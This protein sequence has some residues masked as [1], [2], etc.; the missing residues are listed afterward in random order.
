MG[1]FS[2]KDRTPVVH[3]EVHR[4]IAV[5]ARLDAV[6]EQLRSYSAL[7]SPKHASLHRLLLSEDDGWTV[8]ELPPAIHPW[9]F[10]NM[11][12]WLL[13]T[14]GAADGTVIRSG[15]T[16]AYAAYSLVRDPEVADC[17]CGID[18]NGEGWT[19]SVPTNRI[20]RPAP[21][22]A[23]ARAVAMTPSASAHTIE[24]LAEDPGRDMNP[25]NAPTVATRKQLETVDDYGYSIL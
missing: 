14:S 10:H 6:V 11:G 15:A 25:T 3:P 16:A 21:V 22:P 17:L 2:K 18:E 23:T 4:T 8:V 24:V 1:L 12:F 19:V 13:D 7:H 5:P 20:V 9:T